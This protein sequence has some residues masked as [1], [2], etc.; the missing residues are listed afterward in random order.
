VKI[1]DTGVKSIPLN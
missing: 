1:T